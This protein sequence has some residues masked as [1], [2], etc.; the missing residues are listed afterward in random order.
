MSLKIFVCRTDMAISWIRSL[1]VQVFVSFFQ[2]NLILSSRSTLEVVFID[3]FCPLCAVLRKR[4][5]LSEIGR[6]TVQGVLAALGALFLGR[7]WHFINV[8]WTLHS[9]LLSILNVRDALERGYQLREIIPINFADIPIAI[10]SD[11]IYTVTK[12]TKQLSP[13]R[14]NY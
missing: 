7:N 1:F 2:I 3:F 10:S 6:N 12:T 14:K 8:E 11:L 13:R 5:P 9:V 4:T